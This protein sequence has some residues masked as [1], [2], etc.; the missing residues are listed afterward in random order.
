MTSY[1]VS[2]HNDTG[3][4]EFGQGGVYNVLGIVQAKSPRGANQIAHR[5]WGLT[6]SDF[7][8]DL[9]EQD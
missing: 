8:F 2:G 9:V 1:R 5:L 4:N 3:D 7:M 6:H